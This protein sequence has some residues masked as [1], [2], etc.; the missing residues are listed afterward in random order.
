MVHTPYLLVLQRLVFFNFLICACIHDEISRKN[1][2][3]FNQSNFS[4]QKVNL[5]VHSR[6]KISQKR[7]HK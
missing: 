5:V 2:S 1:D 7:S 6:S 3:I 4:D